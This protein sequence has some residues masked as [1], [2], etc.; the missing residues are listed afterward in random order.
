MS[1]V[2]QP[3]TQTD[4]QTELL[5]PEVRDREWVRVP[6]SGVRTGSY[7]RDTG[8]GGGGR[9][10][11]GRDGGGGGDDEPPGSPSAAPAAMG[12]N[13]LGML[14]FIASEAVLFLTLIVTFAVVRAGYP[15]WPPSDQP[16]LPVM[17]SFFNTLVLLGSG[18]AMF[19]AWRSIRRGIVP[20]SRRL[21]ITATLLGILF[22]VV[23]GVEWVRLIDFGL[24]VSQNI[25]GAVFY[26][27]VGMHG[28]HVFIA[29]LGLLYVSRKFGKGA[30]TR[31]AH[32]GL[33]M[34]GMFWGF[35]VLVWPLLFV[36]VY[37]L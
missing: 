7:R 28:L 34:G 12:T 30:Y 1:V 16:R 3:G 13:V 27:M 19:G 32:D 9:G 22:L 8:N 23:Q 14:V 4:T 25:Y 6:G 33:T 29:V 17:M 36:F 11:D 2:T 26:V 21:L 18:A 24:T 15:E 10:G 35:V 37:L 5:E 31:E 20:Y